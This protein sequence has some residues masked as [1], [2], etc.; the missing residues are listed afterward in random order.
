MAKNTEKWGR[1]TARERYGSVASPRSGTGLG[2]PNNEAPQ[3]PEDKRGPD[4]D[5]NT[6]DNWLRG[7]GKGE[8]EGKPSFDKSGGK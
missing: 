8:A 4:Y 2:D 3:N 1:D 5:N 6:P 7:M